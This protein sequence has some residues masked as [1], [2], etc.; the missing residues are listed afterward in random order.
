MYGTYLYEKDKC[1]IHNYVELGNIDKNP[2]IPVE[3]FTW[4]LLGN[5]KVDKL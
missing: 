2:Y 1:L 3:E 5:G 4:M